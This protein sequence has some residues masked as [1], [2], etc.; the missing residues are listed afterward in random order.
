[1]MV[2]GSRYSLN[3][4]ISDLRSNIKI[5]NNDVL[6]VLPQKCLRIDQDERLAFVHSGHM[7]ILRTYVKS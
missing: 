7:F 5:N 4:K 1:M 2:I 3:F 6:P